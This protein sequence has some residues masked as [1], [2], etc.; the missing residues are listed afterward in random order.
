MWTP[1]KEISFIYRYRYI[2][3]YKK[4]MLFYLKN[5]ILLYLYHTCLTISRPLTPRCTQP[6]WYGHRVRKL[7]WLQI[8]QP[9]GIPHMSK[10]THGHQCLDI[11][12][13]QNM[14]QHHDDL[15]EYMS[16][17]QNWHMENV[18]RVD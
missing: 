10:N 8:N 6:L 18:H 4:H 16:A 9:G 7:G 12:S 3:I 2:G 14:I 15:V 13:P 5:Y 1:N 11:L 17:N